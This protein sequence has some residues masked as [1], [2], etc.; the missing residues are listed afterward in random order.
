MD[1]NS[2]DDSGEADIEH[3]QLWKN[4]QYIWITA[5]VR[6]QTYYTNPNR[7]LKMQV[8]IRC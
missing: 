7:I 6:N 5:Y 4:F 3:E 2:R 8:Q 1:F